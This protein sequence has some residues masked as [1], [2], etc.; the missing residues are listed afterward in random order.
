MKKYIVFDFDGT[1]ADT[2][3]DLLNIAK[4]LKLD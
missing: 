2:S 3:K 4:D 1:I